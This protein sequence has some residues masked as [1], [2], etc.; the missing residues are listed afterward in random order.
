[1]RHTLCDVRKVAGRP[2][3]DWVRDVILCG[4][5]LVLVPTHAI[6]ALDADRGTLSRLAH[7][8]L[9]CVLAGVL[10]YAIA[11]LARQRSVAGDES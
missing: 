10:I 9:A 7:A 5:C 6:D 11:T 1:M 8:L 4:L 3:G 2:I